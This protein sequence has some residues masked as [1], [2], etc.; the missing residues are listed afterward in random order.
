MAEFFFREESKR[1]YYKL[2]ITIKN[3]SSIYLR[4]NVLDKFQKILN[5]FGSVENEYLIE[6]INTEL[7]FCIVTK[8]EIITSQDL[9]DIIQDLENYCKD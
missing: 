9:L 7:K 3:L 6:N 4:K 2:Q 1:D 5:L 8:S